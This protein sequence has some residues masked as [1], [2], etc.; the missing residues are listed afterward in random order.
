MLSSHGESKKY[1][2]IKRCQGLECVHANKT[3]MVINVNDTFAHTLRNVHF[4]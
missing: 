4:R 2:S 3:T 1:F